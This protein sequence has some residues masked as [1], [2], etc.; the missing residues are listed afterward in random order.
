MKSLL[1]KPN[2]LELNDGLFTDLAIRIQLSQTDYNKAVERYETISQWIERDGSPLKNRV[3]LFYPQGSMAIGATI[4]SRLKTDEFDIDVIAQLDLPFGIAPHVPLDLLFNA[5]RGEP[6]SRYF[7]LTIRRTRCITVNYSDDM[8]I[9]VT[10]VIREMG[11]H[12]RQSWLFHDRPEFPNEPS[13]SL[14]ANPYGFAEWFKHNTPPD[15][16]FSDFYTRRTLQYEQITSKEADCEPVPP[17]LPPFRKSKA[18]IVLQ[19]LKRWRNVQYDSRTGRRPPSILLAKLVADAAGSTNSLTQELL[20]QAQH[21]LNVFHSCQRGGYRIQVANPVCYADVLTDRWPSCLEE[22]E[23]FVHDLENLVERL[24]KLTSGCDLGEMQNIMIEL[25][26]ELPT[27]D[28]FRSYNV[29]FGNRVRTGHSQYSPIT[30][31][32]AIGAGLTDQSKS[33]SSSIARK[34]KNHTFYGG[35]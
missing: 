22:Q 25:F 10:P 27:R 21:I 2:V 13:F 11:T 33:S 17:K 16:S 18:V 12:E 8:H 6:G 28:V 9:D 7:G 31:G 1:N 5:I 32:F 26:G 15:Q 35:E 3:Q 4:A 14:T 23:V 19:L 20:F 24:R 29:E 30:G 34:V